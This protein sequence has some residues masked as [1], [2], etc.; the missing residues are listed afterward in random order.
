MV[1]ARCQKLKKFNCDILDGLFFLP[2][3]GADEALNFLNIGRKWLFVSVVFSEHS[4]V[5][6][7]LDKT[8]VSGRLGVVAD[9][10]LVEVH[11]I[12]TLL[13]CPS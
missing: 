10:V 7:V 2:S 8:E 12:T 6:R 5:C 1:P 13:N 3:A 4:A 11:C 9:M